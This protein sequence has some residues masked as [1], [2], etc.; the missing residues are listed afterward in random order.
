MTKSNLSGLVAEDP[1]IK[2]ITVKNLNV[3]IK[4]KV[5]ALGLDLEDVQ[6]E[7]ILEDQRTM[8]EY[9]RPSWTRIESIIVRLTIA[10]NNFEIKANIIQMVQ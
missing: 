1:E 10:T 9:A 2:R 6:S 3:R 8:F 7:N 4:E 5:E